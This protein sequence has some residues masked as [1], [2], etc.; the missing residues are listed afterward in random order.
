MGHLAWRVTSFDISICP[1][2]DF[3]VPPLSPQLIFSIRIRHQ[4]QNPNAPVVNVRTMQDPVYLPP[5]V[6]TVLPG[7]IARK[8]L[9]DVQ[10]SEMITVAARRPADNAR[11]IVGEGA[12]VVG[13]TANSGLVGSSHPGDVF[14]GDDS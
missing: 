9:S 10:T 7:Q 6:C 8:K 12:G 5:E 4:L 2:S 11:L 13:M 3:L 1:L 14:W